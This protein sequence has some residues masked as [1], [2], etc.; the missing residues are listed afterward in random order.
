MTGFVAPLFNVGALAGYKAEQIL[1]GKTTVQKTPIEV[2]PRFSFMVNMPTARALPLY[3]P[4]QVL[5]IAQIV[6]V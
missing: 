6:G 4:M 5:R 2:L 1:L 3:P